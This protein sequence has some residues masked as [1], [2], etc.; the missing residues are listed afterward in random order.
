[1]FPGKSL[2]EQPHPA[3]FHSHM[4][5]GNGGIRG[6]GYQRTQ[7]LCPYRPSR[8]WGATKLPFL[9][10]FPSARA[11]ELAKSAF[12]P[13]LS[14]GRR[15]AR[16]TPLPTPPA[17]GR[18]PLHPSRRF[19][20]SERRKPASG[21]NDGPPT[22][23]GG[24]K[25][26]YMIGVTS[27]FPKAPPSV[28]PLL[29]SATFLAAGSALFF[30]PARRWIRC[31]GRGN[32]TQIESFQTIFPRLGRLSLLRKSQDGYAREHQACGVT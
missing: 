1:M 9:L 6:A 12:V 3:P 22:V 21:R 15:R 4:T 29:Q 32:P 24:S 5:R 25:A 20:R 28:S 17:R 7:I 27:R 19:T 2:H 31:S 16:T 10:A 14:P 18:R 11:P 30:L 13:T 8:S 26:A 23:A